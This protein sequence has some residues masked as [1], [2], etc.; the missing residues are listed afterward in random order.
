M[1]FELN[2]KKLDAIKADFELVF[3]QDKN[4]KIFNKEKDFFKLN[5]YKGEGVLLDLN[6][7]KLYL[8]LKSLAYEDIRLSL[9]T[10]YKTLEKLNIK[11]VKLPSIIGD[12]V[13]RSFASLVEGV[14]FGAYKFDKYKSEKKTSTLEKF[15]ISSEE[16]NGKKFNKDEAKIGLER[17]E[18]LAN[19]TN[20][21]KNIVNEIPE[22]YTPLKMAEDAQNLAK[23]NKNIICKIYDE[24]FLAKEKMNAFLA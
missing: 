20:F 16:L 21:T 24:K 22:I 18:I 10:A 17:G 3:I 1:K 8:E 13:V 15:I 6:N 23:E 19:A 14:L 4:L 2:D 9:C 12:C 5:N 11:S 7:K